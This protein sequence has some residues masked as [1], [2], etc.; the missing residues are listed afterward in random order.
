MGTVYVVSALQGV[1]W[2]NKCFVVMSLDSKDQDQGLEE[3]KMSPLRFLETV[4]MW[5]LRDG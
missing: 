1:C 5:P 4:D 3:E 2:G